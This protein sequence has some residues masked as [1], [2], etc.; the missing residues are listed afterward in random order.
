M[1]KVWDAGGEYVR[2]S[3]TDRRAFPPQFNAKYFQKQG[4]LYGSAIQNSPRESM[5]EFTVEERKAVYTQSGI[6]GVHECR[7]EHPDSI[8][9]WARNKMLA[10]AANY[11]GETVEP[12]ECLL[13]GY[14]VWHKTHFSERER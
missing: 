11:W 1:H 12:D 6:E 9:R 8:D 13:S 3:E 10:F 14:E 7:A 5:S 4:F 2:E